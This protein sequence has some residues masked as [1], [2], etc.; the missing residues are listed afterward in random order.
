[1]PVS[2]H[3]LRAKCSHLM[4]VSC[5]PQKTYYAQE[6]ETWLGSSPSCV[7]TPSVVCKLFGPAFRRAARMEA[8][9]NFF[10]KTGPFPCNRHIFQDHEFA[11][12]GLDESQDKRSVLMELAMKFQDRE[13]Q[14]F[15]STTPM[16]KKSSRR[17]THSSSNTQIFCSHLSS[18]AVKSEL[19]KSINS[20]S[21]HGAVAGISGEEIPFAVKETSNKKAIWNKE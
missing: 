20:F 12:H 21:L 14:T 15:L 16:V 3:I 4:M 19:C 9:V 10:I 7:V 6:I 5:S 1:L 13:H 17:P 11:C 2:H 18:K 8:S